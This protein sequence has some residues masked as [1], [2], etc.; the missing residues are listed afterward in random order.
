[1]KRKN[2]KNKITKRI[3]IIEKYG[4]FFFSWKKCRFKKSISKISF[5]LHVIVCILACEA[6]WYNLLDRYWIVESKWC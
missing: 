5:M 4:F 2:K 6:E 1:M 3:L